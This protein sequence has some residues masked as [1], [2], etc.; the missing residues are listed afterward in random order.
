MIKKP[1]KAITT[2]VKDRKQKKSH[3]ENAQ[4]FIP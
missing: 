4:D 2:G 1:Q 3:T